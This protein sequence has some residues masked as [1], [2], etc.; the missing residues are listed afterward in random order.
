MVKQ[1]VRAAQQDEAQ[2][3]EAQQDKV[4]QQQQSLGVS[5]QRSRRKRGTLLTARGLQRLEAA[6]A[7]AEIVENG[8]KPYT[9]EDLSARSSISL[10]TLS[11]V[12]AARAGVDLRSLCLLFSAFDLVL[13]PKDYEPLADDPVAPTIQ[14]SSSHAPN[15][16]VPLYPS[17]PLPLQSPVYIP[18]PP[19]EERA[20]REISQPGCVLRIK[21]PSGFGKSSLLV[22]VLQTAQQQNQAIASIHLR[23]VDPD[24]LGHPHRFLQW[25]CIAVSLQLG[26]EPQIQ[27]FWSDL[28]GDLLSAT[29]Y[30][31]ES[32][33]PQLQSPILLDIQELHCLFSY[34][35]T[36]QIFFPLLRSWHENARHEPLW[37]SLRLVVAYT[38]DHYLPLDINQSPFNIGLSLTLPEFTIEQIQTLASRYQLP[39]TTQD[40]QLLMNLVGGHPELIHTACYAVQ[41]E[42]LSLKTLIQSAPTPQGIYRQHLQKLSTSLEKNLHLKQAFQDVLKASHPQTLDPILAHQLEGVGLIRATF[43]DQWQIRSEL[44]HLYYQNYGHWDEK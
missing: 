18:R 37:Q 27:Q 13:Q 7:Q 40:C 34:P 14:Q 17:G 23:Q 2:Q 36:A 21:A 15:P 26:L 41:Y 9:L 4:K 5:S 42:Q 33:F 11:R 31:Q 30:F 29:V 6:I 28:V 43:D 25:F 16:A 10:S 19:I 39:W 8:G 35:T 3:D 44:Y 1:P 12:R 32:I 20:C 22:R 24:I 38:T